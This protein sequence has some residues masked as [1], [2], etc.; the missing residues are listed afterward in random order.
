[1]L[2]GCVLKLLLELPHFVS[3]YRLQK[4]MLR[5]RVTYRSVVAAI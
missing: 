3:R 2:L 1:M 5:F 4:L